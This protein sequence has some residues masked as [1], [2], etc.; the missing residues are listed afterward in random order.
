MKLPELTSADHEL[1]QLLK[2]HE[3][4]DARQ[5][6][7]V[8]TAREQ[9][10]NKQAQAL[11][12]VFCTVLNGQ[13]KLIDFAS[14]EE[15]VGFGLE[16][17]IPAFSPAVMVMVDSASGFEV[18]RIPAT[19]SLGLLV[20]PN[21]NLILE[22]QPEGMEMFGRGDCLP[23]LPGH[24]LIASPDGKYL[25]VTERQAGRLQIFSLT[26][27]SRVASFEIREM[28]K[29]S[30]IQACFVAGEIWISDGE[31]S[32]LGC[33][34]V[35]AA[36]EAWP[37]MSWHESRIDKLGALL[38]GH[39][40]NSLYALALDPLRLV[41]LELPGLALRHEMALLGSA[42]SWSAPNVP[43]DSLIA[44][45]GGERVQLL[46]FTRQGQRSRQMVQQLTERLSLAD[47]IRPIEPPTQGW[48]WMLY[49]RANPLASWG[50]RDLAAFI[51]E[52]GFLSA[53]Y[54]VYLRQEARLG[55][56]G[57][58]EATPYIVPCGDEAPFDVLL[59]EAPEIEFASGAAE[60]VLELLIQTAQQ[61]GIA[62]VSDEL[63][64]RLAQ[65]AVMVIDFLRS[66]YVA[67]VEVELDVENLIFLDL[68][69]ERAQLLRA[70]DTTLKGK[71]L[72]WRPG[73]RCPMCQMILPNPRLCGH[74][75][76]ALEN[77]DWQARRRLQSAECCDELIPGQLLLALP[78]ARRVAFLDT[79]L[80]VISELEGYRQDPIEI[81]PEFS[82]DDLDSLPVPV[83]VE[84]PP[85]AWKEPVAT[86]A[87]PDGN[88]LICDKG[89]G[90]TLEITP[91]GVLVRL[92]DH[93]FGAPVLATFRRQHDQLS[94]IL[95]L[96][97]VAG[98]IHAFSREGR[99]LDSWGGDERL[100]LKSPRDLQATW[101]E[102]FLITETGKVIEWDPASHATVRSWGASQG[103]QKPVLARRQPDG[104]TLIVDAG[105]GEIFRFNE[106]DELESRFAY[107]PP[108]EQDAAWVGQSAPDRMMV[109]PNGD[110]VALGKRYWMLIQTVAAKV[111]WVQP[112]TGARRPPNQKQR[113]LAI[114]NEDPSLAPLRNIKIFQNLDSLVLLQ[115]KQLIEPV[116]VP[117]GQWVLRPDDASGTLFSIDSGEVE[118][119]RENDKHPLARLKP[120]DSF[121]EIPLVLGETYSAGFRAGEGL[122]LFQLKRGRY[123]Q[124]VTHT[125]ELGP[126]LRELAFTRKA[127][128]AQSQ[129]IQLQERMDRVKAQ[130]V[131]RRLAEL[132]LFEG[133]D[134]ELLEELAMRLR[135]VAYMP[136]QQVF[137]QGESGDTLYFIARGKVGVYLEGRSEALGQIA[138]GS[139][140]GEMAVLEHAER[141]ATVKSEGYCQVYEIERAAL[142]EI[143]A[144]EPRLHE[145][146]IALAAGRRQGLDQA[147]VIQE[148]AP[149]PPPLELP[150]ATVL[151]LTRVRP[152][153]VYALSQLHQ[154]A[155]CLD[156]TGEV[157]WMGGPL[158][159]VYRPTRLH[160]DKELIWIADTGNDRILALSKSEGYTQ[161]VPGVA[162]SQP[163][164]V[165]PTPDG[166]LLIADAG[167]QRLVI[168]DTE[169]R[170]VWEYGAPHEIMSP[171]YAEATLKGTVLFCDRELQMVF[172]ID[173][174][175]ETPIW[176]HGS[177]LSAGDGPDALCEPSCARRLA[178]GG[179]IIADTGN[180][181]L[182]LFSPV[183]TLMRSFTGTPEIPLVRPV[184]LEVLANGEMLVYPE[185]RDEVIRLGLGGQPIWH[186]HL[187]A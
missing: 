13:L 81:V 38:A 150:K 134:A 46:Y 124:L 137:G 149:P 127:L 142:E 28:G 115:L 27:H 102:T 106:A 43:I 154:T 48:P 14:D 112:W 126:L 119:L 122:S 39:D 95:V 97:Q 77:A 78:Q 135:S 15:I 64:Q 172:E 128:L 70:L 36:G 90:Q 183:G 108:P 35:P 66:H 44:I 162:L 32:C 180:D 101:A 175:G 83:K 23:L 67:M 121:G 173:L 11:S 107:W 24:D 4:L 22:R 88:W 171:W 118:L 157:S 179:T 69:L 75:D 159:K 160:V 145:R 29:H 5:I 8:L 93:R 139:V 109:M 21:G 174:L 113:L 92:F 116:T 136:G 123:K 2:T 176:S 111:R 110:L 30:A 87:L 152:A 182:L 12:G 184:H 104:S 167:Q 34:T 132:A 178:N 86:L 185:D 146:L 65:E 103:L 72:P 57:L 125:G 68:V 133:F 40:G 45:H 10:W 9:A 168:V 140:F 161:R 1:L 41:C 37:E 79:W 91:A 84:A 7:Q 80:Q 153:R 20:R 6:Q 99:L 76:F 56:L 148:E 143:W 51:V 163:R 62:R 117:A 151:S 59:R 52:L 156:E 98:K 144:R 177:L 16:S 105:R 19:E 31:S 54:L 26:E 55:T 129:N 141:T 33:I 58:E 25:V 170:I 169:G 100:Q 147:H 49:S 61:Q 94:D 60:L 131:A 89:L 120:G 164:S 187:P 155:F 53:E 42:M 181:R 138:S 18:S 130:L 186:A 63:A 158:A 114:A 96:D 82:F 73:H 71:R 47:D 165:V 85:V 166:R 74:C 3:I 50:D 17:G